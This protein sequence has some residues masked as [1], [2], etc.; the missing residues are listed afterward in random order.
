[1]QANRSPIGMLFIGLAAVV[2]LGGCVGSDDVGSSQTE[3]EIT[4]PTTCPGR[5]R[6]CFSCNGQTR[7]CALRCPECAPIDTPAPAETAETAPAETAETPVDGAAAFACPLFCNDTGCRL[8]NGTCTIA[9][10]SCLCRQ[11]GGHAD[12]TCGSGAALAPSDEA[13]GKIIVG[14]GGVCGGRTCGAGE[15]CCNPTCSQCEPFGVSCTQQTC[16]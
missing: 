9:C 15:Y 5:Q 7:F 12:S 8:A 13:A 14:G 10:N 6:L 4:G 1:M 16:D 2:A 3:E 11:R